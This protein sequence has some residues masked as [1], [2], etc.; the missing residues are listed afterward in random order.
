MGI[1]LCELEEGSQVTLKIREKDSD[2]HIE[3]NASIKK[4]LKE[5]I[6]LISLDYDTS[7]TLN[8]TNVHIDME[9]YQETDLPIVWRNV[10]II[11]YQSAYFLQCTTEGARHNRRECFRVGVSVPVNVHVADGGSKNVIVR[12]ISLSGFAI[13]DRKKELILGVGDKI[14]LTLAD[15]GFVLGLAGRVVRTEE[16][17]DMVIYGLEICNLC[18][19]L[20]AYISAKQRNKSR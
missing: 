16:H 15:L 13:T 18:K 20:P 10:K 12:D 5:N 6:S 19:D 4:I 3:M 14:T 1:K 9:Y 2:R 7:Q 8:F 11:N 17:E